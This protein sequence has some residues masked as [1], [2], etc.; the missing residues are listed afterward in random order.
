MRTFECFNIFGKTIHK[1]ASEVHILDWNQGKNGMN[2]AGGPVWTVIVK[3]K[4][5]QMWE[6]THSVSLWEA[7]S[8]SCPLPKNLTRA[9]VLNHNREV[10]CVGSGPICSC[11]PTDMCSPVLADVEGSVKSQFY[12]S[13]Y[14]RIPPITAN[15]DL[16]NTLLFQ[17]AIYLCSP[18]AEV[19]IQAEII[20]SIWRKNRLQLISQL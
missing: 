17:I 14:S 6:G 15:Y 5:S 19:S 11:S 2:A 16:I 10:M 4:N 8:V 7:L 18:S 20:L 3:F 13:R 12:N 1:K 9:E